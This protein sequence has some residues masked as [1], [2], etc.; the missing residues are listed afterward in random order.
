MLFLLRILIGGGGSAKI[1]F[2]RRGRGQGR[3]AS[4][5]RVMERHGH[6][7]DHYHQ[8]HA[9]ETNLKIENIAIAKIIV[10]I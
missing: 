9:E 7:D 8:Q 5:R 2:G 10:V 4:D 1:V 6:Y 3:H